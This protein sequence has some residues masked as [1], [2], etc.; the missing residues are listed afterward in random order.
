MTNAG[1]TMTNKALAREKSLLRLQESQQTTPPLAPWR[2]VPEL[3]S[4]RRQAVAVVDLGGQYCHLIAR[5]LREIGIWPVIFP[6]SVHRDVLAGFGGVILSGG[7]QSVYDKTS[8]SVDGALSLPVPVLGVCY[9]HQLLAHELGA[10]VKPGSEEYGISKLELSDTDI[11]FEG[12]PPSQTVWMSHSDGVFSLPKTAIILART[13]RCEVAAFADH[14][15]K[16]YGVQFHPE[17]T[18]TE[19]GRRILENFALKVC[20]LQREQNTTDRISH[21]IDQIRFQVGKRSVFFLVSGGVDSTVAF[22]LCA[23]ALPPEQLLGVYVDTGLMRKGETDELR[24]S[25]RHFGVGA[26]LKIRDESRRFLN[27]LK[28]SIE[29]EEKRRIIGRLFLDVQSEAMQ[30]YSID[31]EH[32]LLGQGTIYPDTIESGGRTGSAA[33]IK[34]H[35]N[36]CDEIRQLLDAGLVIEPL[37]EFYKDEVRRIGE[38]LGLPPKITKR[39]PFPGP[40]LAIRCLCTP[41]RDARG[42]LPRSVELPSEFSRYRAI[43]LPLRSVGVQGDGR[44]YRDVVALQGALDYPTLQQVSSHLCNVGKIHNRVILQLAGERDLTRFKIL[45][46]RTLT[47]DRLSLLREADFIA[48]DEMTNRGITDTVWQFPVVLIPLSAG[49]GES[50]V[51]RPVNSEDGMTANFAHLNPGILADIAG[52]IQSLNDINA[53]FL[54]ISDKPPATIEWE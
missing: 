46:S 52:Q 34:T 50:I 24:A 44:T 39:W 9:G 51:L 7:P 41:E 5:R 4:S 29:P 6:S 49:S 18:H 23:K 26:R 28:Q 17:V 42:H 14:T 43:S 40:G 22:T 20:G 21:L 31:D 48:R 30:E 36:R 53:V 33:L 35:H 37:A 11:L 3:Q 1:D 13:E 12:T 10:N 27:A 45:P 54:D 8:P 19:C 25:L 15:R 2:A 32:W 16:L 47:E 38:A